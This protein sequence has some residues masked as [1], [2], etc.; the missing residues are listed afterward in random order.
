MEPGSQRKCGSAVSG[1][2]L[3]SFQMSAPPLVAAPVQ[4]VE[5]PVPFLELEEDDDAMPGSRPRL[6]RLISAC[7]PL[8]GDGGLWPLRKNFQSC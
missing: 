1:A 6:P 3:Y 2:D 7:P 8:T 5:Q 4:E